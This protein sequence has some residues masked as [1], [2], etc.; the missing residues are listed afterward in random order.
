MGK[1]VAVLTKRGQMSCKQP[2]SLEVCPEWEP[3]GVCL[4]PT[5]LFRGQYMI[6]ELG[7]GG[8]VDLKP[9]NAKI[10]EPAGLYFLGQP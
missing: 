2:A 7:R 3:L 1:S 10:K 4:S 8:K 9:P 6:T 5:Q